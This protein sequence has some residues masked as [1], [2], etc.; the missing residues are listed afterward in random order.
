[1]H[2][3]TSRLR[4]GRFRGL[5]DDP[6]LTADILTLPTNSPALSLTTF[7]ADAPVIP[8]SQILPST[9]ATSNMTT[10]LLLLGGLLL[11]VA[12]ARK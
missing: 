6:T 10:P 9:P 3:R 8:A 5:G 7:A 1:M 4:L 2:V 11:L 12:T